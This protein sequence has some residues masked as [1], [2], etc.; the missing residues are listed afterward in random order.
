MSSRAELKQRIAVMTRAAAL[1]Q[2]QGLPGAL[3][4]RHAS[5]SENGK[6]SEGA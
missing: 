4:C 3:I 5:P 2:G 6:K 1:Q